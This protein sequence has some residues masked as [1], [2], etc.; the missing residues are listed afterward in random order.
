MVFT[1]FGTPPGYQIF[2]A[3]SS[4]RSFLD[5]QATKSFLKQLLA[6]NFFV[7]SLTKIIFRKQPDQHI[8]SEQFETSIYLLWK[9]WPV[10]N[11]CC[12]LNKE[13]IPSYDN[14]FYLSCFLDNGFYWLW[15]YRTVW[16]R[17]RNV[18]VGG[19]VFEMGNR[20]GRGKGNGE[21]RGGRSV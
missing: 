9:S 16:S 21:E 14:A 13:L 8:F 3:W 12:Y 1:N 15:V 18:I 20:W 5:S 11:S 4:T 2:P 6:I 10:L 17:Y 7:N 19:H